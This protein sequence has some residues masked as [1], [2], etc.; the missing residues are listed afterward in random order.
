MQA[1]IV[2]PYFVTFN[3]VIAACAKGADLWEQVLNS[4][5]T[6]D[7]ACQSRRCD[8]WLGDRSTCQ[9]R[10][11]LRAYSQAPR[12]F[13]DRECQ[14]NRRD[15]RRSTH[16]PNSASTWT[17]NSAID[18]CA[19]A[20]GQS[21]QALMLIADMQVANVTPHVETSNLSIYACAKVNEQ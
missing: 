20:N 16:V 4:S 18:A 19:E 6:C 7:R 10:R 14:P 12:R 21:E 17:F 3:L 13:L 2:S 15:L 5:M 9:G 11:P 8:L 1:A